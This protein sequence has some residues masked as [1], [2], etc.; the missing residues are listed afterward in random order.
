MAHRRRPPLPTLARLLPLLLAAFS[1]GAAAA[2]PPN[3]AALL[4][5]GDGAFARGEFSAA[6]RHYS[7]A[8]EADPKQALFYTKR[9]AA[10]MSLR[11]H[12]SALR[13]LDAAVAADAGFTQGYLHRGKL[14]RQLCDAA[15]ARADLAEVE[16]LKPGHKA[17]AK[18][19]EAVALLEAALGALDAAEA[20]AGGSS[21]DG[22][23]SSSS[24]SS[25]S[26]D[27]GSSGS[28]SSNAS[29]AS[30]NE[31]SLLLRE[32]IAR[33]LDAAP[34]CA[35]AQLADARLAFAAGDYEQAA[36]A[37]GRL[38]KAAPGD[39]GALVLRGRAYFY[40]NDFDLAKRHFGEALRHDPDH[41]A[42]RKAFGAVKD[43]ERRRQRAARAEADGDLAE[44][45]RQLVGA[46]GVDPSHTLAARELNYAI[47][48]LRRRLA[49]HDDA[50]AACE[51]VL[52]SEPGH[53]GALLD[54][55]RI[56]LDLER[57]DDAVARARD[58]LGAN[59]GD[60][61]L[62][63][64]RGCTGQ[65]RGTR[66]EAMGQVQGTRKG[67]GRFQ[68]V[69]KRRRNFLTHAQTPPPPPSPHTTSPCH[70]HSSTRRPSAASR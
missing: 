2:A 17:A 4:R 35:R 5:E 70:H 56:L 18:E 29:S 8:I 7:D 55:V 69:L 20:A 19:L 23:D 28:S 46:L 25:S 33:V 3:A 38:L 36:A 43:L 49:R 32:A 9:A 67:G 16:R 15:A 58:A 62:H 52:D 57:F 54:R 6:V 14:R 45:E 64:V 41:G 47:C 66:G 53:R 31:Q 37:T 12:A 68:A 61:E 42:A 48:G 22:S 1:G 60:R 24:S 13:D 34:D 11:Q 63:N 59:Q 40:L 50:L 27:D 44:A 10:H 39:L 30:G 26:G 65:G 21:G 51:A